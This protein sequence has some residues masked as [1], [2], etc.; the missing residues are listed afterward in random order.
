MDE[1]S[2]GLFFPSILSEATIVSLGCEIFVLHNLLWVKRHLLARPSERQQLD[3]A[4]EG[5]CAAVGRAPTLLFRI[6]VG[7]IDG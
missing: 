5:E 3:V 1:L 2:R 4:A 7:L 6:V